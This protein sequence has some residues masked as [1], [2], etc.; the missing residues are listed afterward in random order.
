MSELSCDTPFIGRNGAHDLSRYQTK[1]GGRTV[2]SLPLNLEGHGM[3]PHSFS[4]ARINA[5]LSIRHS[6]YTCMH[7]SGFMFYA[8]SQQYALQLYALYALLACSHR[9]LSNEQCSFSY[10]A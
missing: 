7:K 8:F 9:L 6:N 2:V 5:L 1:V 4:W 10:Y 3:D